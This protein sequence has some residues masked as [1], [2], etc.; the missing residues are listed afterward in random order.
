M[1]TTYERGKVGPV[2]WA[3]ARAVGLGATV[4]VLPFVAVVYLIAL[5]AAAVCGRLDP[6]YDWW[7]APD[8]GTR[9]LRHW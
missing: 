9:D 4:A 2:R 7:P 3:L 8:D 6:S 1:E 5:T